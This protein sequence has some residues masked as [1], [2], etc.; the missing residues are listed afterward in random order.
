MKQIRRVRFR[1]GV[2]NIAVNY[3]VGRNCEL[4]TKPEAKVIRF[5]A[6]VGHLK[7]K[8]VDKLL[9]KKIVFNF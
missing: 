4:L 5:N 8:K 7:F 6:E 9:L 2:M 3:S 1:G